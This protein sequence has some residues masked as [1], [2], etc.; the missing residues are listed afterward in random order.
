[1]RKYES[2]KDSGIEWIGEIPSHWEA[3]KLGMLLSANDGGVWG[4][5]GGDTYVLRSTEINVDGTWNFEEE[6]AKR[7][8]SATE[9]NKALLIEGDLLVTKSSGSELHIGKTAIV[10]YRVAKMN[11]CYSNFMQRLRIRNE[12][13]ARLYFYFLNSLLA[14]EQYN[15]LSNTTTGLANLGAEILSNVK[16]PVPTP[17]E[18]IVLAKYL[19]RRTADIDQLIAN[20][21]HLLELYEEEKNTIVNQA[22]DEHHNRKY[23]RSC[24]GPVPYRRRRVYSGKCTGL[25]SGVGHV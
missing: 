2:Y 7:D 15:Y 8:L 18:Q 17:D 24:F 12:N 11:C 9:I 16:V 6:P 25:Q 21:K 14:R 5:D 20:K 13:N 23:F 22:G 10:D 1:M 3:M 19:D 4:N